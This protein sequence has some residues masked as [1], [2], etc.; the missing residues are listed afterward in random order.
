[1]VHG[2]TKSQTW[3]NNITNKRTTRTGGS[4]FTS[5]LAIIIM[6]AFIEYFKIYKVLYISYLILSTQQPCDVEA[7]IISISQMRKLKLRENM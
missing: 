2:V 3:L 5:I 7:I 6:I 1:M 4:F